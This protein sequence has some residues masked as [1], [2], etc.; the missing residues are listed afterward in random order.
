M[1]NNKNQRLVNYLSAILLIGVIVVVSYTIYTQKIDEQKIN[2]IQSTSTT[3]SS[4]TIVPPVTIPTLPEISDLVSPSS[5]QLTEIIEEI[6]FIFEED[7]ENNYSFTDEDI[8]P[9]NISIPLPSKPS[10]F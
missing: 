10:S 7:I 9:E 8:I 4:S 6:N 2:H 5:S 3:L 1:D